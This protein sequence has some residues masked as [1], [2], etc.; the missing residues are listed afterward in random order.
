MPITAH[1]ARQ[2]AWIAEHLGLEKSHAATSIET[3]SVDELLA[4][5]RA[6]AREDLVAQ[7][8]RKA[9]LEGDPVAAIVHARHA[10]RMRQNPTSDDEA[11]VDAEVVER[12][13]FTLEHETDPHVRVQAQAALDRLKKNQ[14]KAAEVQPL[15]LL[16]RHDLT[17]TEVEVLRGY[18]AELPSIL[19]RPLN[20][21]TES[22][23]RERTT[24]NL[25]AFACRAMGIPIGGQVEGAQPPDATPLEKTPKVDARPARDPEVSRYRELANSPNHEIA[26]SARR[27]LKTL[28]SGGRS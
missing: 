9:E 15:D 3:S 14:R 8:E 24:A 7:T 12:L 10:A 1:E 19:A 28:E 5:L 11:A 6:A 2:R 18:V 13:L 20:K 26:A 4:Q 17:A 25:A 21:L 22:E 16:G 23:R 27:I